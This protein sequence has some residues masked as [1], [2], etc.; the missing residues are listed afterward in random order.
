MSKRDPEYEL[1]ELLDLLIDLREDMQD[2]GIK[3]LEELEQKIR[4]LESAL[5]DDED[6]PV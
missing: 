5:G 1:L 6:G 4:E 3:T 2:V